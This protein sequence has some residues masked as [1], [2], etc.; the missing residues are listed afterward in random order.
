MSHRFT[1]ERYTDICQSFEKL[2]SNQ[3]KIAINVLS[4]F[5][6]IGSDLLV[7]KRLGI[8]IQNC[9][10]VEHDSFAQA[11]CS[12][13]HKEDVGCYHHISTFEQMED[14]LENIMIEK[15]RKFT[16]FFAQSFGT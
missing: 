9:I 11:V 2:K 13:H 5:S 12:A 10:V 3:P 16:L 6:G 7:L 1:D 15:G 8:E 14:D 4:I